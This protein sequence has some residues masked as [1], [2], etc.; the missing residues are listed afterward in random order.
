MSETKIRSWIKSLVWRLFGFLILGIITF[1]FT[2]DW[3]E[4]LFISVWFNGLR[5]VLY[6]IH[7]R[8]WLQIKWGQHG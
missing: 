4:S 5:F 6:F 1:I 3:S 2:G 8:I 7:E